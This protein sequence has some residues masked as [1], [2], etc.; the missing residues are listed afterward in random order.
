MENSVEGTLKSFTDLF[1]HTVSSLVL[2]FVKADK[3][4]LEGLTVSEW[5]YPFKNEFLG[6]HLTYVYNNEE[7]YRDQL[8]NELTNKLLKTAELVE[9]IDNKL[10][11]INNPIYSKGS[12]NNLFIEE[13]DTETGLVSLRLNSEELK[14]KLLENYTIE[15]IEPLIEVIGDGRKDDTI[16]SWCSIV[17]LDNLGFIEEIKQLIADVKASDVEEIVATTK[18]KIKKSTTLLDPMFN[19]ALAEA[20][21]QIAMNDEYTVYDKGI[22]CDVTYRGNRLDVNEFIVLDYGNKST[23]KAVLETL[24]SIRREV[25]NGNYKQYIDDTTGHI[26]LPLDVIAKAYLQ[27]EDRTPRSREYQKPELQQLIH[28][29]LTALRGITVEYKKRSTGE[30]ISYNLFPALYRDR[31]IIEGEEYFSVWTFSINR[32]DLYRKRNNKNDNLGN[33]LESSTSLPNYVKPLTPQYKAIK[34]EIDKYV[35]LTVRNLLETK[36]TKREQK[37]RYDE[38]ALAIYPGTVT[39]IP[40]IPSKLR[41]SIVETVEEI[42][43]HRAE[44]L[45]KGSDNKPP[46]Y[47]EAYTNRNKQRGGA[48]G[49]LREVLVMVFHIENKNNK[50][51][52]VDLLK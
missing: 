15:E 40:K 31:A 5:D 41:T 9:E 38:L 51:P 45:A 14:N 29:C 24:E 17:A 2:T 36:Q 50:L 46:V 22:D 3:S 18:I 4:L 47:L 1:Q 20:F 23:A 10:R 27:Q 39:E 34:T 13:Q 28:N 7:M 43:K 44:E 6:K 26:S 49:G 16:V 30:K 21:R 33:Y 52:S 25:S 48:G 32:S 11:D 37:V 12:N 35:D 19:K 42:L 8:G